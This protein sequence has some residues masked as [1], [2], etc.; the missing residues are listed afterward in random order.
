MS[1]SR[2]VPL[3]FQAQIEGRCQLQKLQDLRGTDRRQQQIYDWTDEW[4]EAVDEEHTPAFTQ[5]VKT[6][7][8]KISWRLVSNSGQEE[9]LIRP[10]F[11]ARGWSYFPGSSMKGVF[12]RA[13]SE[14]ESFRYCG[15]VD[16]NEDLRP[17]I[18]RFH[19]GYP[20]GV[21]WLDRSLVD[22]VHPQEAWQVVDQSDHSAL[23]Q[24]SLYQPTLNF[25]ISSAI[26]LE[27]SEW[28]HIWEIWR[29]ALRKGIGSRVSAAYG[30]VKSSS[31]DRFLSVGLAGEGVAPRRIDGSGEFRPNLFKAALRGHTLRLFSGITNDATAL[32]LT[33]MLWGGIPN[34]GE[35]TSA[36]VGFLGIDF[37]AV[38]SNLD[39]LELYEYRNDRGRGAMPI[40]DIS[41]S[42]LQILLM[43]GLSEQDSKSLVTQLLKF[44]M[45][46]GG[47]GK[48]WRR[49]NHRQFFKSYIADGQGNYVNPMIG[50]H[51]QFT[52]K[53][54]KLYIPVNDLEND[55]SSFLD[56]LV[57]YLPRFSRDFSHSSPLLRQ[58]TA[59]RSHA[60]EAWSKGNVEVWGRITDGATSEA[61]RWFHGHYSGDRG[62]YKS[63][64]TGKLGKIGRIWH[65]M[66]PRYLQNEAGGLVA[67]P[68]FV[69]LLTIFP[70]RSGN[71]REKTQDFLDFLGDETDFQQLW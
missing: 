5:N 35:Q 18:L 44:A 57:R 46:L 23:A 47:F 49:I 70:N 60:R 2:H 62:I 9:S 65:R 8:S 4:I 13:C 40:Y 14:T 7:S 28:N 71:E 12:L 26:A 31:D 24:I 29:S 51:W 41:D 63:I 53:S 15:G 33:Q 17:G 66:Y 22:I 64:L 38:S 59:A 11:G 37:S 42:T 54:Q 48:S 19:G 69:E 30:R 52:E 43:R 6:Q 39:D 32:H 25:G 68:D 36:T 3:M 27:E 16:A 58:A 55:I 10:I 1:D 21:N 61:V 45:L 34:G 56:K 67:T 50:C 20:K